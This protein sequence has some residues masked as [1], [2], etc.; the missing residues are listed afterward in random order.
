MDKIYAKCV[1]E[2]DVECSWL[3]HDLEVGQLYE[4][5]DIYMGQ[6][7]TTIVLKD[8]KRSYNSVYFEFYEGSKELD[9]YNDERFNPY[10]CLWED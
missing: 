4:V 6:S 3:T 10:L 8:R 5:H 7:C 9:I 2:S 1:K